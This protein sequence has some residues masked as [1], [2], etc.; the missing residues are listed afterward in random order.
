VKPAWKCWR[1]DLPERGSL[2]LSSRPASLQG[3]LEKLALQRYSA[4]KEGNLLR[5][6]N[7]LYFLDR[8]KE[9]PESL[10]SPWRRQVEEDG[11]VTL[12]HL[13]AL[14]ARV[15]GSR[16]RGLVQWWRGYFEI[17]PAAN[18]DLSD[19]LRRH[20]RHLQFWASLSDEQRRLVRSGGVL[21][22]VQ[23]TAAQRQALLTALEPSDEDRQPPGDRLWLTP[24]EV[25][26]LQFRMEQREVQEQ[27]FREDHPGRCALQYPVRLDPNRPLNSPAGAVPVAEPVTLDER[28]FLYSAAG[29]KDPFRRASIVVGRPAPE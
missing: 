21:T 14:S 27:E 8:P 9:V 15:A 26:T 16:F 11:R 3:L 19:Q 6:R 29:R 20:Q 13:A 28:V 7:E 10:L 25:L 22:I 5:F 23:L 4:R 18:P 24:E 17:G 2:R 12:D 1:M